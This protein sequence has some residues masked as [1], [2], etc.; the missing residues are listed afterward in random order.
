MLGSRHATHVHADILHTTDMLKPFHD[1][2]LL[3][4]VTFHAYTL[5]KLKTFGM[6]R[7]TVMHPIYQRVRVRHR[8]DDGNISQMLHCI[9][10]N[11]P[12][13]ENTS[14]MLPRGSHVSSKRIQELSK[15]SRSP[16]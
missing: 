9:H 16:K 3:S 6:L 8:F 14:K 5:S 12:T 11:E 13:L 2:M 7:A 15:T 4:V 10:F 1:Y